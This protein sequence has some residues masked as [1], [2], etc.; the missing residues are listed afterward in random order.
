[1]P[2]NLSLPTGTGISYTV[3]GVTVN[4]DAA[5]ETTSFDMKAVY[6]EDGRVVT[7][8]E[9]A[10]TLRAY[11]TQALGS[12]DLTTNTQLRQLRQVLQTNGGTFVYNNG[13]GG[14]SINTGQVRD[15]DFGP[16]PQLI[17]FKPIGGTAAAKIYWS[18]ICRVPE[19][20]PGAVARYANFIK[21]FNYR[22]SWTLT[23]GLTR[24]TITGFILIPNNYVVPGSRIT[25]DCADLYRELLNFP[26]PNG[27]HRLTPQTFTL[28]GNRSREDFMIVDESLPS[29][30]VPPPGTISVR[31]SHSVSTASLYSSSMVGRIEGHYTF[32]RNVS[33][34]YAWPYFWRLVRQRLLT[35]AKNA[36]I[37]GIT[38]PRGTSP[39]IVLTDFQ[40]SEPEIYGEPQARFSIGYTF[41]TSMKTLL[42][43]SA[44][45]T[46]VPD[47]NYT[48]WAASMAPVWGVRGF[49]QM[50][51]TKGEVVLNLCQPSQ[52]AILR[53]FSE[54]DGGLRTLRTGP[55]GQVFG[56][57]S[58]D[59]S[60]LHFQN[61]L[62]TCPQDT[63]VELKPLPL[64]QINVSELHTGPL[65]QPGQITLRP[66]GVGGANLPAAGSSSTIAQILS[67]G[68]GLSGL[69]DLN[70]KSSPDSPT[71]NDLSGLGPLAGYGLIQ[72]LPVPKVEVR[73]APTIY[74]WLIGEALRAGYPINPPTVL[75]V[76][77]VQAVPAN[78]EGC[79]FHQQVAAV[80]GGV[81]IIAARWA[82]RW[83]L[84]GLPT[85]LGIPGTPMT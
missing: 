65:P 54:V 50:G 15:V 78:R 33:P 3:N 28:S 80:L 56:Y 40:M 55:I 51:M 57:P 19:C 73:A 84:P 59:D 46:P 18:I 31:A 72:N 37:Q 45:W 83:L 4:F 68:G 49:D 10:L 77:G 2:I 60:W 6:S 27:F 5:T 22:V 62:R 34:V 61:G 1:M 81:P 66:G 52:P 69:A 42:L 30:N 48:L 39:T 64:G 74:V 11:V 76:G 26:V 70:G 16:R 14:I 67:G 53:Q 43:A 82:L 7:H 29:F 12:G 38:L 36:S 85:G 44:L 35:T 24:R 21:E 9:Y 20:P 63:T 79:Y 13:A 8:V 41:V 32:P 17:R 23:R 47:S 58:P 25:N 71:A 75:S